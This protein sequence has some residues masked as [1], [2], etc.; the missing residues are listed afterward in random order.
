MPTINHGFMITR[1]HRARTPMRRVGP[2]NTVRT[3]DEIIAHGIPFRLLDRQEKLLY[4]GMYLGPRAP[5]EMFAP[6]DDFGEGVGCASI[7]YPDLA[8]PG[9]WSRL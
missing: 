3:A 5:A 8:N 7:Q 9:M 1:D 6:Q 2:K 4:E